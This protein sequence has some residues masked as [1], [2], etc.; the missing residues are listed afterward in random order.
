[1][2]INDY[3]DAGGDLVEAVQDAVRRNDYSGLSSS[4]AKTVKD[5]SDTIQRDVR[6]YNAKNQREDIRGRNY[7]NTAGQGRPHPYDENPYRRYRT[8]A[9]T[10]YGQRMTGAK[11]QPQVR[12]RF[13]TQKTPF[14]QKLVSRSSGSGK[15][16]G[17]IF[18]LIIGVPM[19]LSNLAELI[20]GGLASGA[21]FGLMAGAI[22][23]AGSAYAFMTGR[24]D[25]ELVKRYYQYAQAVGDAEYIEIGKL[26]RL[27]GRTKKDVLDDIKALMDKGLLAEAWL[28]EQETT[29]I[30]TEEVY[31]QYQQIRKQ[32]EN[33]RAQAEKEQETDADLPE[34]AREIIKEGQEYIRTIHKFNDEIPGVEMSEKLFRLE[35]TMDRIVEQVRKQ[36]GS[37]AELRKLMSYYLP[38]TVK[39]L[40]AYKELDRQTVSGENIVKT[41]KEIE[42]ALDTINDAFEKLLDSMFQNMAWDVSS[43]ISVMQ[44]M[45][46]QDGLTEQ[47]MSAESGQTTQEMEKQVYGTTLTWGDGGGAAQAQMQEENK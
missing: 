40:S 33:L 28:D 12:K 45:F 21:L 14:L 25:K 23:A 42:E 37:A 9:G 43:D 1:M 15:V 4:I 35:S 29:L 46:A 36:P 41:K 39:L 26:A 47:A 27:T 20:A 22:I 6:E 13:T 10:Q 5:V 8:T 19:V 11:P 34:N 24:K 32:S 16:F 3:I 31:D 17:G 2:G 44:T 30:L 38:T 7:R 18:G